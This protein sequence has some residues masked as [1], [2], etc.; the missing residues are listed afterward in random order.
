MTSARPEVTGRRSGAAATAAAAD[1]TDNSS[2]I[3]WGAERIAQV[4]GRPIRPTFFLL[5]R[6][7]LPAKKVGK[8]WCASRRRLLAH[9]AGEVEVA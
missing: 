9:L 5:E 3:L 6:G 1:V 2:D 7:Y 4:I 8:L